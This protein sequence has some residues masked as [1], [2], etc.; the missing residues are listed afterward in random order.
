MLAYVG[1]QVGW[2]GPVGGGAGDRESDFFTDLLAVEIENVAA[3]AAVDLAA[4]GLAA[5]GGGPDAATMLRASTRTTSE[6]SGFRQ[7][8]ASDAN[9]TSMPP[10]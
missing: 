5:A 4:A 8:R 9:D 6:P 2:A 1:V 3:A 10:Y 7:K